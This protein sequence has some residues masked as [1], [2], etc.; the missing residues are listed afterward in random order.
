MNPD[1]S[2]PQ[3]REPEPPTQRCSLCGNLF[4]Y[5]SDAK[6]LAG[7]PNERFHFYCAKELYDG[8]PD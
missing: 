2:K 5:P 8:Y 4:Q 3:S 7:R 6:R 1:D